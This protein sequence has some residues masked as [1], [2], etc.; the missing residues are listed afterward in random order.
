MGVPPLLRHLGPRKPVGWHNDR[1]R[2]AKQRARRRAQ[3]GKA[4]SA[5]PSPAGRRHPTGHRT[6]LRMVVRADRCD[7]AAPEAARRPGG[8]DGGEVR[9][10]GEANDV[11]VVA[12]RRCVVHSSWSRAGHASPQQEHCPHSESSRP[13]RHWTTMGV[14][15]TWRHDE[16][17]AKPPSSVVVRQRCTSSAA[18][19]RRVAS[20][21]SQPVAAA[22]AAV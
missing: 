20:A 10:L 21:A 16:S 19:P 6:E 1:I 4:G 9:F 11:A 2:R 7:A 22:R 17:R 8:H 3:R 18:S 13:C 14:Y 5:S 15:P 12:R